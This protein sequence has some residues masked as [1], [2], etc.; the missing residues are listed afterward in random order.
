MRGNYLI[1][2]WRNL[3]GA[4]RAALDGAMTGDGGNG[5]VTVTLA[6]EEADYPA[7]GAGREEL[8]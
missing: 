6:G 5:P 4:E 7:I 2:K 3:T 1:G 8:K